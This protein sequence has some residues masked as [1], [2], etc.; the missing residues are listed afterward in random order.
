MQIWTRISYR[1]SPQSYTAVVRWI[2]ATDPRMHDSLVWK[3]SATLL[4]PHDIFG[5]TQ[6]RWIHKLLFV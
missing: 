1:P 5:K 6:Q 3:T 4:H 2:H